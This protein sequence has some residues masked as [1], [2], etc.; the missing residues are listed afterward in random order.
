MSIEIK[1]KQ[2]NSLNNK[3]KAEIVSPF[4]YSIS[5]HRE[6]IYKN[7]NYNEFVKLIV[8]K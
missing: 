6:T 2:L 7:K 1:I 5:V 4:K 3:Q 8:L